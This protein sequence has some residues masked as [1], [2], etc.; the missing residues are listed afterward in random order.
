[1]AGPDVDIIDEE[2][3]EVSIRDKTIFDRLEEQTEDEDSARPIREA[4]EQF[5][6]NIPDGPGGIIGEGNVVGYA[7][8]F[9]IRTGQLAVL[10]VP[11]VRQPGFN[12]ISHG[13]EKYDEYV[14]HT[15]R[16]NAASRHVAQTAAEYLVAAPSNV[17]YV[18]AEIETISMEEVKQRST[19]STWEFAID[20]ADRGVKET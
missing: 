20:V 1:M 13:S 16:V 17:D 7:G 4:T 10:P 18:T 12:V 8:L 15:V 11:G 2:D 5:T 3:D 14:R 6:D 9:A 19:F